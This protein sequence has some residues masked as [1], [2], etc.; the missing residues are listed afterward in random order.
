MTNAWVLKTEQCG[1]LGVY[2]SR[3]KG[4]IAAYEHLTQGDH[5]LHTQ[6]SDACGNRVKLSGEYDVANIERF[7]VNS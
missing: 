5:T 1:I 6:M 2:S 7:T 3:R 4:M